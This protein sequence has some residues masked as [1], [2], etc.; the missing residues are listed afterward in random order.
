M[1]KL[2]A[3]K[4]D[5]NQPE[6][7]AGLRKVGAW[8]LPIHSIKN[9]F[10]IL[11]GYRGNL[12]CMEIK[13]PEYLPKKYDRERLESALETGEY[14]CLNEMKKANINYHIV[15]TI[16]EAIQIITTNE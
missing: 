8:V 15:A 12:F 11:V 16:E 7:V 10:D 4:V 2:R 6:I 13:N 1:A 9:A 14:K 5:K 3:S